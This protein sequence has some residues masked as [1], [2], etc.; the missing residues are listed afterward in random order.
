ML[1]PEVR[2]WP[3]LEYKQ[4]KEE[5]A[6]ELGNDD[7]DPDY[8]AVAALDRKAEEHDRDGSFDRHVGEDVDRF[9]GPPPL[10]RVSHGTF[11]RWCRTAKFHLESDG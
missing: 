9:T 4:E 8:E 7:G 11:C 1:G 2:R 10:Q 6:V 3:A 5:G